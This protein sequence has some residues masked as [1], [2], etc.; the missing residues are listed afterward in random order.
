MTCGPAIVRG[1][2]GRGQ[3]WARP[4]PS[5]AL[6]HGCR[7]VSTRPAS[8]PARAHPRGPRRRWSSDDITPR[9]SFGRPRWVATAALAIPGL[10]A[11]FAVVRPTACRCEGTRAAPAARSFARARA[12]VVMST[13][14]EVRLEREGFP[15]LS[16]YIRQ[17]YFEAPVEQPRGRHRVADLTGLRTW[18]CQVPLFYHLQ[19]SVLPRLLERA[20]GRS[21]LRVLEL[22]SGCGLLGLSVAGLGH[23]VTR[24]VLKTPEGGEYVWTNF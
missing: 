7:H 1:A 16:V 15:R 8:G 5:A 22:G 11:I 19:S 21:S 3:R 20:G 13:V 14:Q 24:S 2:H 4:A 17:H 6:I 10:L 12:H 9:V 18:H 23:E